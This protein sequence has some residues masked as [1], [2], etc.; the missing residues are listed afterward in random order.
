MD[1]PGRGGTHRHNSLQ[2]PRCHTVLYRTV[3]VGF[4][5]G[6]QTYSRQGPHGTQYSHEYKPAVG[7]LLIPVNQRHYGDLEIFLVSLQIVVIMVALS[8]LESQ[9]KGTFKL[10][11][12]R[13]TN[14]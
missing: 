13:F 10:E 14:S 7:W 11:C 2:A 4:P 3:V 9:A 12:R 5:T 8:K 1:M 6:R